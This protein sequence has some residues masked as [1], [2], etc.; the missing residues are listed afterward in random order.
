MYIMESET[1]GTRLEKKTDVR[2]MED[3]LNLAGL[4]PGMRALDAG[5]G[6]GAVARVMAR[7]VGPDGAVTALDA[8][9]ARL[10]QGEILAKEEGIENLRFVHGD[11]LSPPLPK[12]SFDFIWSRFVFEYLAAPDEV[13]DRLLEL[14]K[15]GGKLVVGDLD[16]N[17]IFH[18]GLD[19]KMENILYRIM[20]SFQGVFDPYAGRKLYRRFYQKGLSDIQ[21]HCLPYHLYAGAIPEDQLDNWRGK[22]MTIRS[23]AVQAIGSLAQ[24]DEFAD[25]FIDF[26]QRPDTLTYSTLFLVSGTKA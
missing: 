17:M 20:D 14:L 18:D 13:M 12:E 10:R 2:E 5:A 1:E 6:T 9:Q 22:F 23:Q 4:K 11:L 15:P 25:Y 21:V 24:Y 19:P 16:G 26:L 3:H 7:L 8:S